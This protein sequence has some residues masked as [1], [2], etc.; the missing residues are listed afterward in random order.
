M[1]EKPNINRI[2]N[3]MNNE[4]IYAVSSVLLIL[5]SI[6][7]ALFNNPAPGWVGFIL[8]NSVLFIII[9]LLTTY[10][11]SNATSVGKRVLSSLFYI[12]LLGTLLNTVGIFPIISK[13]IFVPKWEELLL[14]FSLPY[15]LIINGQEKT[16]NEIG[17]I[18]SRL[19]EAIESGITLNSNDY[20]NKERSLRNF[21]VYPAITVM[22]IMLIYLSIRIPLISKTFGGV[23]HSD[24]Y[25][26][27]VPNAVNMFR[28]GDP[29]LNRNLAYIQA[30]ESSISQQSFDTFGHFPLL[31]WM[32]AGLMVYRDAV[33]LEIVVRGMLTVWGLVALLINYLF[34]RKVLGIWTAALAT[35]LLA[36]N[37]L[38]NL[39][40][41]VTV[42]DL[43]AFFFL[44]ISMYFYSVDRHQL[45][46]V[47][48]GLSVLSKY[49]FI[50]ISPVVIATL[51]LITKK[52][53]ISELLELSSAIGLLMIVQELFIARI[54][55]TSFP[56]DY[57]LVSTPALVIIFQYYS[58][59]KYR[60]FVETWE[61]GLSPQQTFALVCSIPGI[62]LILTYPLI[63]KF[64]SGFLTTPKLLFH[65]PMYQEIIDDTGLLMPDFAFLFFPVGIILSIIFGKKSEYLI[66]ILVA[67]FVYLVVASKVIYFHEYYK[68]I[69]VYMAILT[70]AYS[71][72]TLMRYT[73]NRKG[74]IN[75]MVV[76][77][78]LV[79]STLIIVPI[80]AT[81]T[82]DKL[83]NEFQ[84]TA[85][86]ATYI[87][88]NLQDNERRLLRTHFRAKIMILYADISFP[89]GYGNEISPTGARDNL[90]KEFHKLDMYYYLSH[91]EPNLQVFMDLM[92]RTPGTQTTREDL[93]LSQTGQRTADRQETGIN[94]TMVDQHL[95]LEKKIGAWRL[96]KI[97]K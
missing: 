36:V 12:S 8:R 55:S 37:Q 4:K 30:S 5:F 86:M 45:C 79:I 1:N 31:T 85:E 92:D 84:G 97:T 61:D 59:K 18:R 39:I 2:P 46:Y 44:L 15:M 35:L 51:I 13:S 41:Y 9:V 14:V 7:Y 22:A 23:V 62:A 76:L 80:S 57:L 69:F 54:P 77:I 42:L 60:H 87:D 53:K 50:L 83:D 82:T 68:M 6:L 20:E 24:K 40:T 63:S 81:N 16:L 43:P 56:T 94:K 38:F 89:I 88:T 90:G 25:V 29:F 28:A 67:C 49:S 74:D 52:Y 26:T 71:F 75:K 73:H 93:I 27:Y 3:T 65:L 47:A 70:V 21:V 96:Y 33:G 32:L 64:A 34:V 91:G 11:Q 72:D 17:H 19:D 66:G 10:V 78:L 58:F 95:E 48:C